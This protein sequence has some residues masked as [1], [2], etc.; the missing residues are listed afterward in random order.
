MGEVEEVIPTGISVIDRHVLGIGGLP[1][2][3][4]SEVFGPEGVGKTSF[5]LK[6]LAQA[7]QGGGLAI[8]AENETSLQPDWARDVHGVNINKLVLIEAESME[9]T[10][11][12]ILTVINAIPPGVGP[13]LVSWDSIAQTPTR[14]EIETG[15]DKDQ[16]IGVRARQLS[17]TCRLLARALKKKRVHL[18]FVNQIRTKIGV[19]FGDPT[20]TPGGHAV[21]FYAS[22]RLSLL[23]GK[24]VK[25]DDGLH[26]GKDIIVRAVKN[27]LYPPWRDARVRLTYEDGWDE[28]WSTLYHAKENDKA[29]ARASGPKALLAAYEALG[30]PVPEAPL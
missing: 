29:G 6:C 10:T 19:M 2:G 25:A 20:E 7:Q 8:L 5:M 30:W 9:Q 4:S 22:A 1:V 12:S 13:N 24:A 28:E 11:D 18:M 14:E 3:R 23:G 16:R 17:R 27:K 26:D 21:K 15:L